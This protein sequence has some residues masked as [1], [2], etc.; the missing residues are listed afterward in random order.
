MQEKSKEA[1]QGYESEMFINFLFVRW[2]D[3]LFVVAVANIVCI[4]DFRMCVCNEKE[5]KNSNKY[6]QITWS[7]EI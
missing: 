5:A 1:G 2:F 6:L 3:H 4:V 7:N